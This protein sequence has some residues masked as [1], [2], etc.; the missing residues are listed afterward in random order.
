MD[1]IDPLGLDLFGCAG[2]VRVMM[3]EA[4]ARHVRR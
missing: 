4:L 3:R 1:H 2:D